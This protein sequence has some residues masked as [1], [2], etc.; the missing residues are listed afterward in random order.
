MKKAKNIKFR[1]KINGCGVV[2]FDNVNQRVMYDGTNLYDKMKSG[3]R[4]SNDN[5]SYAKKNFYGNKQNLSYKLKISSDCLRHQIF[6]NDVP[7]Q[8]PNIVHNEAIFYSYMA[9][10]AI[11][12][13]GYMFAERE[14]ENCK[15]GGVLTITC[16]EQTCDAVS[17]IELFSKS[18]KKK[19]DD[20][21]DE[22]GTSLFFK[23]VVGNIEYEAIG[24]INLSKL[25][26]VSCDQIFDRYGFNPDL[27]WMYKKFLQPKMPNFNS[28]LGYYKLET[29][30][31]DIPEYGFKL[32]NENLVFLTKEIL[33]RLLNLNIQKA[34]AYAK[35]AE[36]QY[37]I[38]CDPIEDIFDSENGW[39]TVKSK[40]DIDKIT[41]D[42]QDFYV[43]AD[44]EEAIAVR[45]TIEDEMGKRKAAKQLKK[46]AEKADRA[47]RKAEKAEREALEKKESVTESV[48]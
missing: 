33:V 14:Q 36:L 5:I 26:F 1:L 8:S 24:E 47:K 41:F 15:R 35:T 46:D 7:Y 20:S 37:K 10:P 45:E 39:V 44:S 40:D 12:V 19:N 43:E 28:E 27:F 11:L 3:D 17:H 21:V 13:R 30:Q 16:A 22:K 18:G 38:V 32:S 42:V 34:T 4:N 31:V 29:S 6:I 23:E 48:E 9:N 25:Q 2:N